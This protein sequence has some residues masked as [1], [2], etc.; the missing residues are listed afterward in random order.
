MDEV[1][2]GA[3]AGP[4]SVGVVAVDLTTRACP[5][6]VADSKLLSPA[7]RTRLLPALGRWGLARAVGHAQPEEIDALGIIA[8]L[9]L[10]GRRALAQLEVPVDLVLLD[11][12]HDWLSLPAQPDLL[13]GTLT[14]L[15]GATS[16]APGRRDGTP[17]DRTLPDTTV[18]DCTPLDRPGLDPTRPGPAVR[19]RIKAD[20]A[21]ASV[22][23]A[24]VLAKC[25][26]DALMARVAEDHPEYGWGGNKGYGSAD[27]VRALREHGPSVL[28]RRSWRLPVDEP[29]TGT[30]PAWSMMEA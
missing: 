13:D 29:T 10:A 1:G 19:T 3:L 2:R 8:A 9:R 23:A 20:L 11:G 14:L 28:H 16:V 5:P 17:P 26:R 4:V 25:E 15:P 7:A 24:S 30:G 22:A 27:H 6:G 12:S 18:R 21:C